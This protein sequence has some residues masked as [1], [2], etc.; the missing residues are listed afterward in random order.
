MS[1]PT[2]FVYD[3]SIL[4]AFRV[5]QRHSFHTKARCGSV[6]RLK[7]ILIGAIPS[8]QSID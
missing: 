3:V 8:N 4:D 7:D 5:T 6:Y 2:V 1:S